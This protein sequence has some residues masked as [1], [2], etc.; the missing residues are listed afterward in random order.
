M[1]VFG[2]EHELCSLTRTDFLTMREFVYLYWRCRAEQPGSRPETSLPESL[3]LTSGQRRQSLGSHW[4][5]TAGR[6][7]A[8]R[9][10]RGTYGWINLRAGTMFETQ[11]HTTHSVVKTAEN[12]FFSR[13]G[14][15]NRVLHTWK[16]SLC[17]TPVTFSASYSHDRLKADLPAEVALQISL[18]LLQL[19]RVVDVVEGGVVKD[20]TRWILWDT[21]WRRGGRGEERYT[22]QLLSIRVIKKTF[23]VVLKLFLPQN[24]VPYTF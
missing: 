18:E 13:F 20:A 2:G 21:C 10:Y 3:Q 23:L 15:F 22:N 19:S 4:P 16:Q 24:K 8:Q 17:L 14:H 12:I 11:K 9:S 5:G 6:W 1:S 7:S